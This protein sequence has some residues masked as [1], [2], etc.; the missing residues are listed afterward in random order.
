VGV[1]WWQLW[2]SSPPLDQEAEERFKKREGRLNDVVFRGACDLAGIKPTPRQARKW[3]NGKGL[4]LRF[5]N[6]AK[7]LL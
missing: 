7:S 6:K 1:K 5:Q 3:N 2:V 4:A